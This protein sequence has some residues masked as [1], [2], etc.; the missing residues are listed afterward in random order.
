MLAMCLIGS[1][2][3]VINRRGVLT[4]A[5][6]SQNTKPWVYQYSAEGDDGKLYFA[7]YYYGDFTIPGIDDWC[8]L[9]FTVPE[10][11]SEKS[12]QP[13]A[14][15]ICAGGHGEFYHVTMSAAEN[16]GRCLLMRDPRAPRASYMDHELT[17]ITNVDGTLYAK[18]PGKGIAVS[19]CIYDER[20]NAMIGTTAL[21]DARSSG[22]CRLNPRKYN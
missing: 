10:M 13:W 16:G 3:S 5:S 20:A 9:D 2:Y 22:I 7:S 21:V 4:S 11:G 17:G 8:A 1:G 6:T 19:V 15:S 18:M 12:Q 14:T